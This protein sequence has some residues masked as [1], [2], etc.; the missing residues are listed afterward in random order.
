MEFSCLNDVDMVRILGF[1]VSFCRS[2]LFSKKTIAL[3]LE[4]R[5]HQKR[6]ALPLARQLFRNSARSTRIGVRVGGPKDATGR[7]RIGRV[8]PKDATGR[9]RDQSRCSCSRSRPPS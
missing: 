8:S 2:H 4:K 1:S 7:V 9:V 6:I 3:P 5:L